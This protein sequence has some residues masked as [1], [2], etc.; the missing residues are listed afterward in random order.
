MA[1]TQAQWYKKLR[2][3]V[4]TWVFE[5]SQGQEAFFQAFAK[6]LTSTQETMEAQRAETFILQSSAPITDLHGQ[7]RDTPRLPGELDGLYK[8]RIRNLSNKVNPVDLKAI[9]DALLLTGECVIIEDYEG[10]S[11]LDRESFLNRGQVILLS[12]IYNCFTVIFDN[13][14][15]QPFSYLDRENFISRD[16]YAVSLEAPEAFFDA[17]VRAVDDNKALGTLFRVVERLGV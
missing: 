17:I 15:P 11:F 16:L 5:R 10:A 7:E 12:E 3:L 2:G 14:K 9:V 1:L 4:P 6:V 13:Q 8:K